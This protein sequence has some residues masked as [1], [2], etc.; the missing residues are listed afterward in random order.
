[1]L[2][3]VTSNAKWELIYAY[4]FPAVLAA[5]VALLG[6]IVQL[7]IGIRS[8]KLVLKS[9]WETQMVESRI[10]FY[11]PF[12][13]L[14]N[15]ITVFLNCHSDFEFCEDKYND[16]EYQ[17]ELE[18]LKKIYSKICKWYEE[19]FFNMYPE[20]KALDEKILEI[21]NHMNSILYINITSPKSWKILKEYKKTDIEEL[22]NNIK[23]EII[24]LSY[25]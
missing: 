4:I 22:V 15:E 25:K 19:N 8:N 1:M 6:I 11:R 13:I 21:Y 5:V 14:I 2:L 12:G 9:I 10:K 18:K 3:L 17:M 23:S 24:K 7:I 20:N 16:S